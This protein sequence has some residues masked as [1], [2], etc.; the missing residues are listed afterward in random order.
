MPQIFPKSWV[1]IGRAIAAGLPLG[2]FALVAVLIA[3]SYSSYS[4]LE[5]YYIEQPLPFSH[6]HHVTAAGIDCRYCHTNV[7]HAAFPG[8]PST[9]ICMNCHSQLYT[10][11]ELLK[12]VR[13]SYATGRAI[14]WN[15]VYKLPDFVYFDHS[16]HVQKGVGCATCHGRV[17][18]MPLIKRAVPLRMQWCLD[19]HRDP[20]PHLRPKDEV[21]NMR[22]QPP[23]DQ[24]ARGEALMKQY[25]IA[26]QQLT[27]CSVCH[28]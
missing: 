8:M 16:I 11:V 17:D 19:C 2:A 13:E 7:E 5:G 18:Q 15:W 23:P 27:D 1:L 25:G 12:P 10:D 21:F 4:T 26:V 3:I 28:R 14:K 24:R 9:S 22:W 20:A 6:E